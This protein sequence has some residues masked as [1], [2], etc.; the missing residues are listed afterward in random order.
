MWNSDFSPNFC[1][2]PNLSLLSIQAS[3]AAAERLFG[4]AGYY[5][6][7]RRQNTESS[8]TEM[9][10]LIRSFVSSRID[11]ATKQVG[12]LSSRAQ[13]VKDTAEEIAREISSEKIVK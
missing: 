9:L 12:F 3:S 7:L 11:G 6:G 4:D 10:L 1:G 8:Y 2:F 5:E 13:V